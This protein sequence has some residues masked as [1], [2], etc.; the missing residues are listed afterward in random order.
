MAI[1]LNDHENRIKSFEGKL[2]DIEKRLNEISANNKDIFIYKLNGYVPKVEIWNT[3]YIPDI[4]SKYVMCRMDLY[5]TGPYWG[6]HE[7]IDCRFMT[8]NKDQTFGVEWIRYGSNGTT[9][10]ISGISRNSN[11][12]G[13]STG[14]QSRLGLYGY[15]IF[16]N[17]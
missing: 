2:P 7:K 16:Y 14:S 15:L 6:Y 1:S 12:F 17:D 11:G 8:V 9:N 5:V 10:T 3:E 4:P 13:I